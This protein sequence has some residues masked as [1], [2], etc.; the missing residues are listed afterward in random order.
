MSPRLTHLAFV[1]TA[2]LALSAGP[3][4]AS[5]GPA[6]AALPGPLVPPTNGLLVPPP[7]APLVVAPRVL[8]ATLSPRH[9]RR[10]QRSRQR[11]TLATTGR[12]RVVL[13]R[14]ARGRHT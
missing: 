2:G 14:T 12:L 1:A 10:G 3:A 9:V 11:V 6:G 8:R 13:E 4:L 5:E 7:V